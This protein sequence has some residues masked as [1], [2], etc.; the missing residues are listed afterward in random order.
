[1][2]GY[3]QIPIP[4]ADRRNRG[5]FAVAILLLAIILPSGLLSA[6]PADSLL[7][8]A[9]QNLQQASNDGSVDQVLLARTMI[10]RA[11]ADENLATLAHYYAGY[12]AHLLVGL[13]TG[14]ETS[15]SKAE[16]LA[17]LDY[18]I[19]HLGQ[20]TERDPS[21]A[22]AWALLASAY[23]RKIGLRPLLGMRLGPRSSRAQEMAVQLEPDNPRVVMLEAIG[24]YNTPRIW[25]GSKTQALSGFR[26]AARLFEEESIADPLQPSWGHS[27][28]YAWL[29]IA[30]MDSGELPE[31]R[32][33]LE[34][35]LEIEPEFGW[36]RYELLPSLERR[37]LE[38]AE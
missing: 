5:R 36:V 7:L 2:A 25:G 31:A 20:A 19:L 32:Q 27:E 1:M 3:Q 29:G 21:F 10:E 14:N 34:S 38:S 13:L 18:A 16:L 35:A 9:K 8:L 17:Y 15:A 6:Q 23:G 24:G 37:E 26:R 33:A 30:Y 11:V 28:V 22:E 4:I 12:S